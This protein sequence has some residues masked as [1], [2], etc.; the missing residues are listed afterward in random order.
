MS[1]ADDPY[2]EAMV[3]K[4]F[5][6]A[7]LNRFGLAKSLLVL[8]WWCSLVQWWLMI[9]LVIIITRD[10]EEIMFSPYVFFVCVSVCLCLSRCLPG[11]FN[12]EGLAPHKNILLVYCWGCLVVQVVLHVFMTS[13]MPMAIFLVYSTSGITSGTKIVASAKW[14]PLWKFWN[15]KHS[16]NLTS[17]MKRLSQIMQIKYF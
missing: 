6:A 15:I 3:E 8:I 4:G 11:R 16:F 13:L 5:P 2:S 1:I 17:D 9:R 12:Y 14:R 10:S 7:I